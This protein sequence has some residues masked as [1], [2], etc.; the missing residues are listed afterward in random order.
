[1]RNAKK[2][3]FD[4][5]HAATSYL[6]DYQHELSS[7]VF[8]KFSG[9]LRAR[10]VK[11]ICSIELHPN[12]G[13]VPFQVLTQIQAFFSKNA[14]FSTPSV[15][16]AQAKRN[17]FK[18][19]ELCKIT[20]KR[21]KHYAKYPER[22]KF[23]S[24]IAVMQ[25]VIGSVLGDVCHLFEQMPKHLRLTSGATESHSKIDSAPVLKMRRTMSVSP[26]AVPLVLATLKHFG[27]IESDEEVY[28]PK[29]DAPLRLRLTDF[30]RIAFVP[31][32][33]KTHR[34]I[35]AEA[36]LNLPFQL[37]IDHHIKARL[38]RVGIDLGSQKRN[39]DL[40]RQGS[41]DGS[42]ATI[43]LSMASD[44]LAYELV[45]VLFPKDWYNIL[46]RLRAKGYKLDGESGLYHKFSSMGNGF[47]FPVETLVFYAA[48]KAAGSD[49]AC[50]YGDDII[51]ET[52]CAR[53]VIEILRFIGFRTNK[54]KTFVEGKFRE[55]CGHDYYEGTNIR[56]F[57]I[58]KSDNLNLMELSHAING[59][60]RVGAANGLLWSYLRRL[61]LCN[62]IHLVPAVEHTGVGVHVDVSSAYHLGLL[63]YRSWITS[64]RGY[65]EIAV[66][67]NSLDADTRCRLKAAHSVKGYLLTSLAHQLIVDKVGGTQLTLREYALLFKESNVYT[68]IATDRKVV[69]SWRCFN[70]LKR[71]PSH[72][73]LWTEFL[74]I[75]KDK[76]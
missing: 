71:S 18:G 31:K 34:S 46:D 66:S 35:A 33:Y 45:K 1:M 68:N 25:D 4:V 64:Y 13:M 30:N 11:R 12:I 60:V 27:V 52:E 50:V 32:N 63:R 55:S 19:E 44:T 67:P 57:F 23:S 65:G 70:P 7:D 28:P 43:D 22:N 36:D 2:E 76:P 47:T 20:N 49:V 29:K 9:A 6:T 10:D 56:P 26:A 38:R 41:I 14:S 61:T 62:N 69:T 21:L 54:E 48:C 37:A 73:Y 39:A 59:L 15:C 72:L 24:E 75:R 5:W 74:G 58:R 42:V 51:V 40:A 8:N 3:S 17:F 16:E 53:K